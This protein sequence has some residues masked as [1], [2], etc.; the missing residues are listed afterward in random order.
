MVAVLPLQGMA[1]AVT[2]VT[3]AAYG[4]RA[5]GKLKRAYF[6][7]VKTGLG[8][9]T[10]I[11]FATFA[12]APVIAGVF[13]WSEGTIHLRGDIVT[14]LRIV[15]FFYPAIAFG[16][17]SSAMFQGIGKGLYSLIITLL[18]TLILGVPLAA[19]FG[20][21]LGM[22]LP[23]VYLGIVTGTWTA[24]LGA[25]LWAS[26]FINRIQKAPET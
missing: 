20:L 19:F 18:R 12:A 23:G 7:A 11:A 25:F 8:V 10:L 15:S 22:G 5:Y 16:M 4:G 3:G 6:F 21:R 17:L 1:T 2:S 24:T 9:E 13:T 26:L 14:L